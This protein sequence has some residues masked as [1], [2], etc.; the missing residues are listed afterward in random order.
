M[1]IKGR[2]RSNGAQLAD[3]LLQSKE[4]DRAY[5]LDI[6]GTVRPDS[7]KK[8]L[9]EMSL[10]SD[11]TK[12]GKNGLYHAQ[13][14]PA[15]GE[16]HPMTQEDWLKA[17]DILGQHLGFDGQKRAIVLHE[18]NGRLHGHVVWERYDHDTGKLRGDGKNYEKHDKARAEIER[19]LGHELTPQRNA[20]EP[21]HQER[22]TQFWQ[23]HPDAHSF[24]EA[25]QEAGYQVCQGNA[26]RPFRVV[27]PDGQSLD[28]VRQLDG[29]KT[30][31]VRDRLQPVRDD[32][33]TEVEALH[34]VKSTR[35]TEQ[36]LSDNSRDLSDS[37]DRMEAMRN[38]Y[39]QSLEPETEQPFVYSYGFKIQQNIEQPPALPRQPEPENQSDK[40]RAL[41]DSQDMAVAMLEQ[42]RQ[43]QKEA[44]QRQ[45]A[46]ND[47]K[48]EIEQ[49]EIE[50]LMEQQRQIRQRG[51]DRGGY[52]R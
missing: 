22:L 47:N 33:Q 31:D 7:L 4:N 39:K 1:V 46:A 11:L 24:I 45:Q 9:L 42:Y 34:R 28:L 40:S 50:R 3:Y 41:S 18:K 5:V 23:D 6:Q 13:I 49:S 30:K 2:S 51:R 27:T 43:R 15:I 25:A 52:S 12:R 29:I 14:N 35:Q 8:S 16:D 20:R 21:T 19:E 37:Q 44:Q 38:H 26:R 48:Q 36:M 10:S 32:L 17:A